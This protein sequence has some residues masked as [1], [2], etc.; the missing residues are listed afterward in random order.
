MKF[1]NFICFNTLLI[2]TLNIHAEL[3]LNESDKLNLPLPLP[4]NGIEYSD[5]EINNF[6][7]ESIKNNLQ[8]I[9]IFGGN[10]CP[11]CRIFAG[12]LNM[13][14]IKKFIDEKFRILHIDVGRY[15]IN[16]DLMEEYGIPSQ[17]GVPRVLV[18]DF[19]RNLIN[20]TTTAEWRTARDRSAQE[21]FNFFQEMN[22]S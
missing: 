16:M 7:D 20:N 17:E 21:I 14:S 12:T 10:W 15:D 13:S 3:L 1:K 11:D 8:P 5:V 9:I 19:E 2:M 22:K 18:F 6:L 4:Y